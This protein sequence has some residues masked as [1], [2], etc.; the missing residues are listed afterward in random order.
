MDLLIQQ[1]HKKWMSELA[2]DT[3]TLLQAKIDIK[4]ATRGERLLEVSSNQLVL[5]SVVVT[6]GRVPVW[7]E[8]NYAT[9]IYIFTDEL[10]MVGQCCVFT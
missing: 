5:G 4:Q 2:D 10:F 3:S 6:G 8:P 1:E 9:A 7:V